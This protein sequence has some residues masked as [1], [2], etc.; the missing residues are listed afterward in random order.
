MI[1]D[2]VKGFPTLILTILIL[3]G[4]QLMAMGII[5]E[6]LGRLFM[7]SKQRPLFLLD[8]YQPSQSAAEGVPK[9]TQASTQASTP[10]SLQASAEFP[11]QVSAV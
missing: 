8:E 1:G 7:E 6:Y 9:S 5:G 3:G 11:S 2:S 4:L 10:A